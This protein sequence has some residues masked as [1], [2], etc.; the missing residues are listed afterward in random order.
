MNNFV[1]D[2]AREKG[3]VTSYAEDQGEVFRRSDAQCFV[4]R[5]N[6]DVDV[7]CA[8]D[9]TSLPREAGGDRRH[10]RNTFDGSGGILERSRCALDS[11]ADGKRVRGEP[12]DDPKERASGSCRHSREDVQRLRN[13][14]CPV[15]PCSSLKE[16]RDFAFCHAPAAQIRIA[17]HFKVVSRVEKSFADSSSL[18]IAS[19]PASIC[20]SKRSGAVFS[21]CRNSFHQLRRDSRGSFNHREINWERVTL[22]RI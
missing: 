14:P 7:R 9:R 12:G 17:S 4:S 11:E 16:Y 15:V 10:A 3:K 18:A 22:Y 13:R 8:S 20:K 5:S 2:R 6:V 21:S 19:S 1:T